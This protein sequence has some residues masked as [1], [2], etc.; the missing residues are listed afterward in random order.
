VKK[1][2]VNEFDLIDSVIVHEPSNEIAQM[3]FENL[4]SEDKEKYLLFDDILYYEKAEK[5]H[6]KFTDIIKVFTNKENCFE[7]AELLREILCNKKI[8]KD[9]VSDIGCSSANSDNCDSIIFTVPIGDNYQSLPLPNIMFTRDLGVSIGNS[10]IITWASNKVRNPENIIAKHI[11][12]NH[13][14]FSGYDIY[15]FHENHPELAFEGGDVTLINKETVA[16]GVSERTSKASVEAITP[17]L[18]KNGIKYIMCFNMPKERRF[19]HLDTVFSVIN[20]KEALIYPPFFENGNSQELDVDIIKTSKSGSLSSA[21]L[22][23]SSAFKEI[24]IEFNFIRC[25]GEHFQEEEQW[26]DGANAFC[27]CPGVIILYDRNTQTILDLEKHGYKKI[28]AND[29]LALDNFDRSQKTVITIESGELSRGRG[30]PRCMT[31]PINRI[32]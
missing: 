16:I 19:M 1:D 21:T 5:E 27:L 31:M 17:F 18:H 29:F 10:M 22:K 6:K 24:G 11:I 20:K 9:F 30:G 8:R 23:A 25:G 4:N 3:K 26:T 28:S 13:S 12:K 7:L 2:L 32:K 14:L 15:D